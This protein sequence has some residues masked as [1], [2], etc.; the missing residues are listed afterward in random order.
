MTRHAP[1]TAGPISRR[2]RLSL[3]AYVCRRPPS[4]RQESSEALA[5]ADRAEPL[6]WAER[7]EV[8]DWN[9][10]SENAD[11]A[12]PTEPIE[13][14]E[15]TEA[16]EITDPFEAMLSSESSDHNDHRELEPAPTVASASQGVSTSG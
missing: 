16:I 10:P 9:E 14:K 12:E 5:C 15:P 2:G 7:A 8:E 13:A 1:A 6:A 11:I 4:A 3:L